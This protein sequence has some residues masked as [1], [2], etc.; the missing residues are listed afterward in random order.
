MGMEKSELRAGRRPGELDERRFVALGVT[1]LESAR[2]ALRE[3]VSAVDGPGRVRFEGDLRG[4][5]TVCAYGVVHLARTA[6]EA[7]P[8]AT[9]LF[10]HLLTTY[11]GLKPGCPSDHP[12]R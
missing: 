1:V 8:S 10:V 9:S 4:L 11:P 12:P 7:A 2:P 3:T 5:T 6:V